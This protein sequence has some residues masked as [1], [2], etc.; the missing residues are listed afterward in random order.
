[1][2]AMGKPM[3]LRE[4]SPLIQN[5]IVSVSN[6][7][8]QWE[9][10]RE[11]AASFGLVGVVFRRNKNQLTPQGSLRKKAHVHDV[12]LGAVSENGTSNCLGQ[13]TDA[14][15]IKKPVELLALY[16]SPMFIVV[17]A[18]EPGRSRAVSTEPLVIVVVVI[19]K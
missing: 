11:S 7:L 14:A 16:V 18:L 5:V 3:R 13:N 2:L 8:S 19:V 9:L 1:M 4:E 15:Y 6:L 10:V 17:G 12:V